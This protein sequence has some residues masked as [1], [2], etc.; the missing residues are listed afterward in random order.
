MDILLLLL[1]ALGVGY[2]W[3]KS[4]NATKTNELR[5]KISEQLHQIATA[6]ST[7]EAKA[8]LHAAAN[9]IRDEVI[10]PS[11]AATAQSAKP[12]QITKPTPAV[13]Q[14]IAT[15]KPQEV[16]SHHLD[17]V[18]VLLYFGAFLLLASVALFVGLSD[19]DG[20]SKT[21]AV[22]VLAGIFYGAGLYLYE[23]VVRL[24]PAAI[25]FTAI[26]LLTLPL[27]GVAAYSYVF[28]E[29]GSTVWL[30]TSAIS[31]ALYVF[32]LWRIRQSFMGYLSVFMCLS[33][34]LSVIAVFDAPMY[35]FGWAAI[36]LGM[37][38]MVVAKKVTNR[39]E[40]EQPLSVSASVMVPTA[41]L[42][43]LFAGETIGIVNQGI[44]LALAAAFYGLA[45][46][47]EPT[48][49]ERRLPYF[50][51]SY[52]LAP[53]AVAV[54]VYGLDGKFVTAS[55]G[56][57]I[58]IAAGM[59]LLWATKLQNEWQHFALSINTVFLAVAA[60]LC[61]ATTDWA[62]LS[63]LLVLNL[64]LFAG[65]T[66][67]WRRPLEFGAGLAT[68]L[69]IPLVVGHSA[70]PAWE[71]HFFSFVYLLLAAL[72]TGVMSRFRSVSHAR[73]ILASSLVAALSLG[74]LH[75]LS[76]AEALPSLIS[77]LTALLVVYV[78]YK[79]RVAMPLVA[80][81]VLG[82][83][84]LLQ[85]L[86][87]QAQ[88]G[89]VIAYFL[90][91]LGVGYVLIGR[92]HAVFQLPA[93]HRDAWIGSGIVL[94]YAIVLFGFLAGGSTP[95]P[96]ITALAAAGITT[97][98]EAWLRQQR[99]V[100]YF[101]GGVLLAAAQFATAEFGW[102]E[103]QLYW[104]A[105]ALYVFFF[106]YREHVAAGLPVAISLLTA[107]II[108]GLAMHNALN[109]GAL[110]M[111]IL[112]VSL[113][114][115]IAGKLVPL[116]PEGKVTLAY[117]GLAGTYL[118]AL[119]PGNTAGSYQTYDTY[120]RGEPWLN[121]MSLLTAGA[122]TTYEAFL[123]HHRTMLYVGGA[124]TLTGL[125]WLIYTQGVEEFQ[126]YTH[127]WALYFGLL[128]WHAWRANRHDEQR[129][130]TGLGLGVLTIPLALAAL[131]GNTTYGLLL[132]LEGTGLVLFGLWL[133]DTLISRWGLAVA[134]GS[135]LYQLR[136]YQFFVLALLGAGII[137]ISVYL[138][139]K[140]EKR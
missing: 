38:Y 135:V 40:L 35:Y 64:L 128:A 96:G 6:E 39:A 123:A 5:L 120:Y 63:W 127:M 49:S 33:L 24:K 70:S 60:L 51:L 17:N 52:A 138:L 114:T 102:H 111:T 137:G 89:S 136:E 19:F 16:Q 57:V 32:A 48:T 23:R 124:I 107:G 117:T 125:Q 131:G 99:F 43:L 76:A 85:L 7:E 91:T 134:V 121:A 12:M 27:A 14:P 118:A 36:L 11:E 109:P 119:T 97:G 25:A 22:M 88:T 18:S 94:L 58:T 98:I 2:I 126:L 69:L 71:P 45:C 106:A 82:V 78:S 68:L 108:H 47:T 41:A 10:Q 4:A 105:W 77:L 26:G 13:T 132:L 66:Y 79:E 86:L 139:L 83:V 95:W 65:M 31:L 93:A 74:W 44:S 3:G 28:T 101:A 37:I 84:A 100:L 15:I 87:H 73:V 42:L 103:W 72:L 56:L 54:I 55:F 75:G 21:L 30:I 129:L 29:T 80:A 1:I 46:W 34:W 53:I 8:S 62:A 133:K 61:G 113:A 67:K 116:W 110:A 59:G 92:L 130:F 140:R 122:L 81:T 112:S 9:S 90:I 115:Y 20:V 50:L 104:Y